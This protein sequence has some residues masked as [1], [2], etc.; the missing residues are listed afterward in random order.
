MHIFVQ[1]CIVS[2]CIIIFPC[3]V[4]ESPVSEAEGKRNVPSSSWP[5]AL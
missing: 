2:V 1:S 3:P 5:N 4:S